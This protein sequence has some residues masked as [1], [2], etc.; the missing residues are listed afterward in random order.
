MVG[1]SDRCS[2]QFAHGQLISQI[3][4]FDKFSAPTLGI[5]SHLPA[6]DYKVEGFDVAQTRSGR[7]AGLASMFVPRLE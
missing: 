2:T 4:A 1:S 3:I 6:R 5:C 7:D